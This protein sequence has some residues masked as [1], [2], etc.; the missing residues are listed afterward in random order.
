MTLTWQKSQKGQRQGEKKSA[1]FAPGHLKSFPG[2]V[3]TNYKDKSNQKCYNN[4]CLKTKVCIHSQSVS[5]AVLDLLK[6]I[7]KLN[8]AEVEDKV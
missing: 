7:L 8:A 2:L 1:D 5:F 6:L 4:E 3:K